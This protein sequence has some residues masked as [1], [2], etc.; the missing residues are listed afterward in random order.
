MTPPSTL[1]P[2]RG[3]F[4]AVARAVAPASAELD[5]GAWLRG[6]SL[7]DESLADRPRSVR[8]QLVLF[9]RIL[10]LMARLRWGRGLA[11]LPAHRVRALL[12]GFERSRTLLLRRGVWGVRTLAFMAVYSHPEV[13]SALG[14][15][16]E[17]A[18][19]GA[20]GGSQGPWPERGGAG[21]PEPGILTAEATGAADSGDPGSSGSSTDVPDAGG[22]PDAEGSHA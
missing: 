9:F 20:R 12:S 1:A 11:A 2:V 5:E 16:A 4:R 18:G 13:R 17:A 7:V 14:Y 15:R 22:A 6:E 21:A 8:R 10:G 19:W 3:A